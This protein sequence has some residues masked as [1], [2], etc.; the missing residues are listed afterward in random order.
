[1]LELDLVQ[2]VAF[3]GVMLFIGFGIRKRLPFIGRY[4]IPVPVVS[5]LLVAVAILIGRNF[6]EIPLKFDTT[7]QSQLMLAFFTAIGFVASISLLARGGPQ[8][9]IFLQ[10]ILGVAVALAF[11]LNPLFGVLAGSVTL[12]GGPATGLAFAKDFRDHVDGQSP[13]EVG[14]RIHPAAL[15]HVFQELI[16]GCL[17]ART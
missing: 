17:Y 5:G 2:T 3:G 8:V 12:T 9:L 7:L 14:N 15:L 10:N 16:D 6:G 11:D 13:S 4:N 1:M